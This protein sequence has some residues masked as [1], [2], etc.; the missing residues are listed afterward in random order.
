[1]TLYRRPLS[2]PSKNPKVYYRHSSLSRIS[3]ILSMPSHSAWT[4]I[5]HFISSTNKIHFVWNFLHRRHFYLLLI[6]QCSPQHCFLKHPLNDK[7]RGPQNALNVSEKR[8][9]SRPWLDSNPGSSIP[10]SSHYFDYAP[11]RFRRER[12]A[13]VRYSS[14]VLQYGQGYNWRPPR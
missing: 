7:V 13:P 6:Y 1:M 2:E 4:H 8:V 12:Y 14:T 9:T 5:S 3:W 10:W 11:S